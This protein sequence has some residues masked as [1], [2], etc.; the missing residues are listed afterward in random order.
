MDQVIN[1]NLPIVGRIQHGEKQISNGKTKVVDLRIFY[2]KST[3]R[4][5]SAV[6]CKLAQYNFNC[7]Y[8]RFYDYRI[9]FHI[10]F[11]AGMDCALSVGNISY[12][13]FY[14]GIFYNPGCKLYHSEK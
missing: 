3:V 11:R 12:F 1:R 7:C 4:R 5:K 2:S 13:T 10:V 6:L 14:V 9:Y 8:A